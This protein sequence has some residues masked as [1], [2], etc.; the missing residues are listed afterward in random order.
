MLRA[1]WGYSSSSFQA[2]SSW[3]IDSLTAVN[4]LRD[5]LES[6]K[7]SNLLWKNLWIDFYFSH[8]A[9]LWPRFISDFVRY[10]IFIAGSSSLSYNTPSHTDPSPRLAAK[11]GRNTF[12]SLFSPCSVFVD[13]FMI[14][15]G[16]TVFIWRGWRGEKWEVRDFLL[17]LIKPSIR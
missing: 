16:V 8:S 10:L 2:N 5:H 9:C 1:P 4:V 13:R 15:I 14:W 12:C 3:L 6:Y 7:C 17:C 11:E